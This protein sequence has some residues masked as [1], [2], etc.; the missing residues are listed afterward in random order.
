MVTRG[1]I[2]FLQFVRR[3]EE[4]F[5][6]IY[7]KHANHDLHLKI[8]W[9]IDEIPHIS[10]FPDFSAFPHFFLIANTMTFCEILNIS[11]KSSIFSIFPGILHFSDP[12]LL[13]SPCQ[14]LLINP[15]ELLVKFG[16]IPGILWSKLNA[17][18]FSQFWWF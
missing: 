6:K 9:N 3:S 15:M 13:F 8:Q 7:L 11:A 14:L 5:T 1:G 16:G 10:R 4:I 12:L 2:Y 17:L 18:K